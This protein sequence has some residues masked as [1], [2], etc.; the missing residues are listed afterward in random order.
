VA[1][2]LDQLRVLDAIARTGGF[3][4]AGREL[5]RTTSAVSYTVGQ[6]E[7]RLGVLLFE[8]EGRRVELTNAGLLLLDEARKVLET[9]ARFEKIGEQ[10]REGWE[11]ELRIVLDGIFPQ[12]PILK[13]LDRFARRRV[14]TRVQVSVGFLSDVLRIFAQEGADLALS[15]DLESEAGLRLSELPPIE[16]LL[17]LHKNHPIQRY[18]KPL[19]LERLR[20][21]VEVVVVRPDNLPRRPPGQL[22]FGASQVFQM[23][24]F[25]AKRDALLQGIGFGWL[26][27][28]LAEPAIRRG[29]LRPLGYQH[30]DRHLFHPRLVRR[31]GAA[32]PALAL[33]LDLLAAELP[34]PEL[35]A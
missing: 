30:G 35:P 22:F 10:L 2:T 7:R 27:R 15:L 18:P 9:A 1:L 20:E 28:H 21:H 17:L 6:L 32:G 12:A 14:P 23:P 5:F 19:P 4:A 16:M 3:A 34:L 13:A 33:L 11:P 25:H 31:D 24:D 26:P 29:T 8:R